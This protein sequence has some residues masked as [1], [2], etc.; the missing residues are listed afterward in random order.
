MSLHNKYNRYNE[1]CAEKFK[2][3]MWQRLMNAASVPEWQHETEKSGFNDFLRNK[4]YNLL[5]NA[6]DIL[7]K[8][9]KH[10]WEEDEAF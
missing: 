9:A 2:T 5:W 4:N 1:E 3:N 6:R 7:T 8:Y 10:Y